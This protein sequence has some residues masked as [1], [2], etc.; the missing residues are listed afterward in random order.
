MGYGVTSRG[1][2]ECDLYGPVYVNGDGIESSLVPEA[3]AM[4]RA[5]EVIPVDIP[6]VINTR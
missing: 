6:L 5:L 1:A 4:T 2:Q 3:S